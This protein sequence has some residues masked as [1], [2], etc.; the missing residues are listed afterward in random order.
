MHWNLAFNQF[1][2]HLF[3]TG[4]ENLLV[5]IPTF[6][7]MRFGFV[8]IAQIFLMQLK[9]E[10]NCFKRQAQLFLQL[11]PDPSTFSLLI[12]FIVHYFTFYLLLCHFFSCTIVHCSLSQIS[13][14][15]YF[16]LS[17][18][19]I[20]IFTVVVSRLAWINF[21]WGNKHLHLISDEMRMNGKDSN[22]P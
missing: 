19:D 10:Q 3:A 16:F 20:T 18:T 5:K 2:Q 9:S 8:E 17:F 22:V 14:I 1:G 11:N 12:L 21:I 6:F 13:N 4:D 7:S 15:P